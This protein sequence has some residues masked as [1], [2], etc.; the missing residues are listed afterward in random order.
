MDTVMMIEV[1]CTSGD[2][3][4]AEDPESAVVAA[5]TLCD[6]DFKARPFYGTT[7]AVSFFVNGSL[8]R[9]PVAEAELWRA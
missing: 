7:R 4:W 8:V 2:T 3:A 1:R 9:G 6:D 5:I